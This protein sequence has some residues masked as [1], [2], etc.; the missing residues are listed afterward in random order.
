MSSCLNC[1][2]LQCLSA[3]AST[4][5]KI[6]HSECV[7]REAPCRRA[8]HAVGQGVKLPT[9]G[10]C[11]W[12]LSRVSP[13]ETSQRRPSGNLGCVY[14]HDSWEILDVAIYVTYVYL[15]FHFVCSNGTSNHSS[16]A[17]HFGAR[18]RHAHASWQPTVELAPSRSFKSMC[19]VLLRGFLHY[20]FWECLK[21]CFFPLTLTKQKA[22]HSMF[23]RNNQLQF[24][25][26]LL[27]SPYSNKIT[28]AS[29]GWEVESGERGEDWNGKWFKGTVVTLIGHRNWIIS[30]FSTIV[31]QISQ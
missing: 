25:L 10:G 20:V 15:A 4:H 18:S 13:I 31:S 26:I 11:G 6:H 1:S 5:Q 30:R 27:A 3:K 24:V 28:L 22:R 19:T 14:T 12:G 8:G 16:D 17:L 21:T 2:I 7:P 29:P 9:N 23:T